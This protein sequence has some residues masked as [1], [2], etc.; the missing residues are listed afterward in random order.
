MAMG[1][2]LLAISVGAAGLVMFTARRG[3]AERERALSFLEGIFPERSAGFCSYDAATPALPVISFEGRDLA[4]VLSVPKSG[5]S[6]AIAAEWDRS[7]ARTF[8]CRFS[9]NAANGSL[10][11]G[12]NGEEEQFG[13]V[14]TAD[15]GDTLTFTDLKGKV[16]TYTVEKVRHLKSASAAEFEKNDFDLLIFARPAL[17]GDVI[18]L[19]CTNH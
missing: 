4:G 9:G 2:V 13:F 6:F 5:A 1:I 8:P 3:K 19:C 16:Y 15:I 14:K 11:L 17:T 7:L 18:L 12:G 10:I